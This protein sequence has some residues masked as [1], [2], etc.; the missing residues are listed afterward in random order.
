MNSQTMRVISK[1][2]GV[3]QADLA[4]MAGVSRQAVSAWFKAPLGSEL[5]IYSS[6]LKKL[7]D[8]LRVSA[9]DLLNPLPVLGDAEATARYEAE[10]LWD[11]LYESLADFSIALI[12]GEPA[13]LARLVQVFG[14]Y[15]SAKIAGKKIWDQFPRY[16]RH[17]RPV[18]R[19]QIERVW[20]LRQHPISS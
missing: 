16:K 15:K 4:K 20:Q 18:R 9:D 13:A 12:R 6:H 3:S 19:E 14:L 17:I 11:S 1:L 10:L 8:H 2:R 5:N 7:A